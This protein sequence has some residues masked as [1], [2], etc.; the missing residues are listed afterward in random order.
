MTQ[1]QPSP[2]P[3]AQNLE[4]ADGR[5][6][7]YA[8][9]GDPAGVPVLALHG[10][11]ACRLMFA[12]ADAPARRLGLRLIAPDRPGYGLT[13][14]DAAPSL[15]KR[16][17]WLHDFADAFGLGRFGIL[18]ISGGAPYSVALAARLGSRIVG[19]AL[20]SPMGPVAD[21]A[22][23]PQSAHDPIAFW[24]RRFF[25][26]LAKRTWL[27]EPFG[28]LGSRLF[29]ASPDTFSGWVPRLAG[30]A[31]ASILSQ[32]YVR[33]RMI[34]MTVEA[35]RQ[36]ALGATSDLEIFSQPWGVDYG[37][38][39]APSMLWQGTADTVVPPVA[40]YHLAGLLPRCRLNRIEGAG[41]FWVFNHVDAVLNEAF[42]V[43]SGQPGSI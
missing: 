3:T 25:L 13:P 7:G 26:H 21:Y 42:H 37:K 19:L 4:L 6:V 2:D 22:A 35:F 41:H 36:G 24:Q 18:G 14:M 38:V 17:G 31:D 10:A 39:V 30:A 43:L 28:S 32:T 9:Y 15:T 1:K 8:V 11:P 40:A 23:T 16:A 29:C 20:V 34:P 5:H 12:I 27:T 33:E